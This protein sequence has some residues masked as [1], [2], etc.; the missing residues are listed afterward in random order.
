[1]FWVI[2]TSPVRA[3]QICAIISDDTRQINRSLDLP[4]LYWELRHSARKHIL[5]YISEPRPESHPSG[6]CELD[7]VF[8]STVSGTGYLSCQSGHNMNAHDLFEVDFALNSV[9]DV[10]DTLIGLV[11]SAQVLT[12]R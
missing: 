1:M 4:C 10:Q 3:F 7:L 6:V 5:V 12:Q 9:D 8:T 11:S 2:S